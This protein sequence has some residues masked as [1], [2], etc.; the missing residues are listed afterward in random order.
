PPAWEA[1]QALVVRDEAM[2]AEVRPGKFQQPDDMKAAQETVLELARSRAVLR[3]ALAD[4]GPGREHDPTKPWPSAEAIAALADSVKL[5]PPKGA[6]FGKT[7]VFYLSV[8][9]ET[10]ARALKLTEAICRHL[11]L[12]S[13]ELRDQKAQSL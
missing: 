13:R 11:Q 3:A 4:V 8:K 5:A 9:A 2:G 12:R 10:P 7:E 1:T 6:E